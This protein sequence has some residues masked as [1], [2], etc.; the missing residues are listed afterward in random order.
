MFLEYVKA[1][2]LIYVI[3]IAAMYYLNYRSGRPI[4]I[5]G[6]IYFRRGQRM[7]YFPLGSSFVLALVLFLLFKRFVA[8]YAIPK[9]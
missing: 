9:P 5:P 8:G 6:D 1:F 2:F 4:V 7:I 3:A